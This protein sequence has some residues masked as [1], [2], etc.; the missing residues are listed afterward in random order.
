MTDYKYIIL[1]QC[2]WNFLFDLL[3]NS[4]QPVV[5]F[6][7]FL[8]YSKGIVKF[9]GLKGSYLGIQAIL[10]VTWGL[11]H[12]LLFAL[13]YRVVQIFYGT[14]FYEMFKSRK[15]L[16]FTYLITGLVFIGSTQA[17]CILFLASGLI[18]RAEEIN[19]R[20]ASPTQ[21][22]PLGQPALLQLFALEPSTSGCD[23]GLCGPVLTTG[24][25][26]LE[27]GVFDWLRG[28]GGN[29]GT[30]YCDGCE[31]DGKIADG[32]SGGGPFGED[33]KAGRVVGNY[34]RSKREDGEDGGTFI[35]PNGGC[36]I[37]GNI[38]NGKDG[39]WFRTKRGNG[40]DGGKVYCP[41][42]KIEGDTATGGDG[43][44]FR[45]KR[46]NEF[47]QNGVVNVHTYKNDRFKRGNGGNGGTFHVACASYTCNV[48]VHGDVANGGHG[49]NN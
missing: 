47:E 38:A 37:K 26:I 20:L 49:G 18:D 40:G 31:I 36:V 34:E 30:V 9:V 5:V 8:A 39:G 27:R 43:G 19:V 10:L 17:S 7:F 48:N 16:I 14:R 12:C 2:I 32:G 44:W 35:C 45:K 4:W 25:Y 28:K 42:C 6:P 41:N 1:T 11:I 3:M 13:F 46:Q 24:V 33:G 15:S 21:D 23:L 22:N 29:G